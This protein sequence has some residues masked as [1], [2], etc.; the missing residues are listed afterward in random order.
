RPDWVS[1]VAFWYQHPP[2]EIKESLPPVAKRIAPYTVLPVKDLAYTAEPSMLVVPDGNGITYIPN[3]TKARLDVTFAVE[4]DGRY[5]LNGIFFKS[6]MGGVY[7]PLLD[8]TPFGPPIDFTI[9]NADFVWQSLD[10]HDLKAGKHTL[11]FQGTE[12]LSPH[13]RRQTAGMRTLGF[14]SLILLRLEDMEGYHRLLDEKTA[15]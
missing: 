15:K 12:I 6:I 13:S 5:Q 11:S 9:I 2:K 7:Q 4:K 1:S 8:G 14:D 10:H 3:T